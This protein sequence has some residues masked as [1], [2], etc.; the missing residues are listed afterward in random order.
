MSFK[1]YNE[2]LWVQGRRRGALPGS[3][4]HRGASRQVDLAARFGGKEFA[5]VLIEADSAGAAE[6]AERIRAEVAAVHA[7]QEGSR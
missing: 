3:A 2:S 4:H 1:H 6:V 5:L 7:D